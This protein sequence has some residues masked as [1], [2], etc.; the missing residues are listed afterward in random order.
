MIALEVVLL[1]LGALSF[2]VILG[3]L[4]GLLDPPDWPN[5]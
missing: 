4:L 3:G 1:V 2:A 5:D